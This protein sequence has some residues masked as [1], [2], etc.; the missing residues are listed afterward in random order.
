MW[1]YLYL[2]QFFGEYNMYFLPLLGNCLILFIASVMPQVLEM[3]NEEV[4]YIY[5]NY[6][7]CVAEGIAK[8]LGE[9]IILPM[10]GVRIVPKEALTPSTEGKK[11]LKHA[12]FCTIKISV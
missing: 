5:D 3:Y 1:P 11:R 4:M 2:V 12:V 6:F 9:D 8:N 7:K 10:S